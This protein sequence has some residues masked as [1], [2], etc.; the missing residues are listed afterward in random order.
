MP[1]PGLPIDRK[2]YLYRSVCLAT[3]HFGMEIMFLSDKLLKK[4]ENSQGSLM[5]RYHSKL[6][7]ARNTQNYPMQ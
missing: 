7:K 3:L 6:L 1:Y 2:I 4:L 5:K